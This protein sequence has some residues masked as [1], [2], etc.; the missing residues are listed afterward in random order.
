ML[1]AHRLPRTPLPEHPDRSRMPPEGYERRKR[2]YDE[3]EMKPDE[4]FYAR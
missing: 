3:E 2:E 4:E 1:Y